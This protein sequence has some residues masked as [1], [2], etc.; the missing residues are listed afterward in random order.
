MKEGFIYFATLSRP[1]VKAGRFNINRTIQQKEAEYRR[2]DPKFKIRHAYY[3]PDVVNEENRVLRSLRLVAG[4]EV[5]G[6]GRETFDMP[7]EHAVRL[8]GSSSA[9]RRTRAINAI[10]DFEVEPGKTVQTLVTELGENLEYDHSLEASARN[11]VIEGHMFD[12]GIWAV[13][14]EPHHNLSVDAY[15]TVSNPQKLIKAIPVL[16]EYSDILHKLPLVR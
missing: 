2:L 4:T 13:A 16:T 12:L 9:T 10:L 14:A 6:P 11:M 1:G 7:L 8:S 3:S 5:K 15:A